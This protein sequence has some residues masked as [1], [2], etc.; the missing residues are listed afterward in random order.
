M[1]WSCRSEYRILRWLEDNSMRNIC[2]E[3]AV[4]RF[5]E[6]NEPL[7]VHAPN[8]NDKVLNRIATEGW[9]PSLEFIHRSCDYMRQSDW[10]RHK[11]E[12]KIVADAIPIRLVTK[13]ERRANRRIIK[14]LAKEERLFLF[15]VEKAKKKEERLRLRQERRQAKTDQAVAK[16]TQLANELQL[17]QVE[18]MGPMTEEERIVNWNQCVE[19]YNEMAKALVPIAE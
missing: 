4:V 15:A 9:H 5:G 18:E 10:E 3:D 8:A 14:E 6:H 11:R 7:P 1:A 2:V 12:D 13:A 19:A 17:K 16:A